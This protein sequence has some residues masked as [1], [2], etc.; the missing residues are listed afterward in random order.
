MEIGPYP[1]PDELIDRLKEAEENRRFGELRRLLDP[2]QPAD[3]ALVLEEIDEKDLPIV[4]RAASPAYPVLY[5][6]R[7]AGDARSAVCR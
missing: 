6:R 5:R 3:V 7:A 1:Q 2:I 4:S